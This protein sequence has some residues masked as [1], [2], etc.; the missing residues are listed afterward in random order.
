MR[1]LASN[2]L[3]VGLRAESVTSPDWVASSIAS[4]LTAPRGSVSFLD[5]GAML[6]LG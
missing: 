5:V 6:P 2:R 1:M 4:D 3:K